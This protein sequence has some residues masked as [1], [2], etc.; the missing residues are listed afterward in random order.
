MVISGHRS[1]EEK[2]ADILSPNTPGRVKPEIAGAIRVVAVDRGL[3]KLNGI[4]QP[5]QTEGV[6][7]GPFHKIKITVIEHTVMH[8]LTRGIQQAE[9]FPPIMAGHLFQHPTV[10]IRP[11]VLGKIMDMEKQAVPPFSEQVKRPRQ[12]QILAQAVV[13]DM[14]DIRR[15]AKGLTRR[16][17]HLCGKLRGRNSLPDSFIAKTGDNTIAGRPVPLRRFTGQNNR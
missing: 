14:P 5:V 12:G 8:M 1:P 15:S 9:H 3:G 6:D 4:R 13:V 10:I 7:S 16:L 2:F 11:S 17:F